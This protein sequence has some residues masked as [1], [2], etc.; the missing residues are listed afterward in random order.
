MPTTTE[1]PL[2]PAFAEHDAAKADFFNE[3][4]QAFE[5]R[6]VPLNPLA[7]KLS[8]AAPYLREKES[9]K[10]DAA[11]SRSPAQAP[12]ATPP[13][14]TDNNPS[15]TQA[16]KISGL[17]TPESSEAGQP[18]ASVAQ[19]ASLPDP[20]ADIPGPDEY[21]GGKG[22]VDN[23]K[24]LH[25]AKDHWKQEAL[26]AKQQLEKLQAGGQVKGGAPDPEIVKHVQMLQAERDNLIA[27]LEAVAVEKSPRFEQ[28]FKPRIEAAINLAK[29]SVGPDRAMHIEKLLS[30]PESTY[31]DEQLDQILNEMGTG[32]RHAKLSQAVAEYD[33]INAEKQALS[34]RGSEVYKQWQSEEQANMTRQ[35]QERTKQALQTFDSELKTW[36]SAVTEQDAAI[37]RD[38]FNGQADLQDA[39]R[40][41]L[42][43]VYGP[44]VAGQALAKDKR[45]KELEAELSKFRSVQ[46]GKGNAGGSPQVSDEVPEGTSYADA[47]GRLVSQQGLLR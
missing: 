34:S 13:S 11:S 25:G 40:A 44:K 27:R 14:S 5:D 24:K 26:A 9:V 33:R 22:F 21:R 30:M 12:A 23:W 15:P 16:G 46:P 1:E 37:A 38:V 39:A 41:S 28:A 45:I 19:S 17:V 31:R 18:S 29:Q 3:A 35:Q 6:R 32:M 42:W 7:E 10:S 4:E 2:H 47:I 43:A 20:D 36:G 8:Q